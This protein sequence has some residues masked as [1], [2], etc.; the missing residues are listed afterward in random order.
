[1]NR[2]ANIRYAP[3]WPERPQRRKAKH[4]EKKIAALLTSERLLSPIWN[5]CHKSCFSSMAA[6]LRSL[7]TFGEMSLIFQTTRS[8][9]GKL[10]ASRQPIPQNDTDSYN[11]RVSTILSRCTDRKTKPVGHNAC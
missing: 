10:R 8:F 7:E 9:Q 5:W 11:L 1:M 3:E 6:H 4:S 2:P